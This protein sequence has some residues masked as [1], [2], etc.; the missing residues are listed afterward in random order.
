LLR[1]QSIAQIT[2]KEIG[3]KPKKTGQFCIPGLKAGAIIV[4]TINSGI[5][6]P[7]FSPGYADNAK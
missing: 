2:K 3:L 7:D 5:I 4:P 6:A 1:Q